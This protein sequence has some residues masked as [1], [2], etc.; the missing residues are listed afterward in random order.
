MRRPSVR[1]I[2]AVAV[3]NAV[4]DLANRVGQLCES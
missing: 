1:A 4:A 3:Q 2:V